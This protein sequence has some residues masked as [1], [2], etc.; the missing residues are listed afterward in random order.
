M[1][2]ARFL[3]L[4]NCR[5]EKFGNKGRFPISSGQLKIWEFVFIGWEHCHIQKGVLGPWK[6]EGQ[7]PK[8]W[9][10]GG[11]VLSMSRC[12]QRLGPAGLDGIVHSGES[13]KNEDMIIVHNMYSHL[14]LTNRTFISYLASHL[15]LYLTHRT[16]IS[17]L[18]SHCICI[19]VWHT[20]P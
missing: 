7:T 5:K 15:Y 6:G 2:K 9:V 16:L 8:L 19:C 4:I 10:G 14:C 11:Q 20:G 3:K 18:T 17:Y 1:R 12:V 13:R